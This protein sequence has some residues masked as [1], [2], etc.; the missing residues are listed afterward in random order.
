MAVSWA[1]VTKP[2]TRGRGQPQEYAGP[3]TEVVLPL[4]A[5][6]VP[7]DPIGNPPEVVKLTSIASVV[8]LPEL[9]L[10]SRGESA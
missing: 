10:Q 4:A 2:Q 3:V 5:R 7:P 1:G 6:N 8:A 9:L